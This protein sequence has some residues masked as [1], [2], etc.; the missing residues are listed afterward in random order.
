MSHDLALL[1]TQGTTVPKFHVLIWNYLYWI[2]VWSHLVF[3]L[4]LLISIINSSLQDN[5]SSLVL[6]IVPSITKIL[7]YNSTGFQDRILDIQD[8]ITQWLA[9]IMLLTLQL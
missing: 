6:T 7:L 4:I 5:L 1:I 8:I 2:N 9:I 3:V